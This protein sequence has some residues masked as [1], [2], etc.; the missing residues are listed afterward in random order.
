MR[1]LAEPLSWRVHPLRQESRLKSGL[2]VLTIGGV[3]VIAGVSFGEALYGVLSLALLA[4]S[5]SRYLLPTAFRLDP[6]GAR[7]DHALRGRTL[8]WSQVRRVDAHADGLFLSPFARPSRLDAFRGAFLRYAG[9][10]E[11]VRSAVDAYRAAA[12]AGP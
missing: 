9:N 5:L 7:V 3:A 12:G 4:V 11:R 10:G 2:L 8:S 6:S 1:A